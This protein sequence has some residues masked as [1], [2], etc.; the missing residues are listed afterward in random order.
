[1]SLRVRTCLFLL[2]AH[3]SACGPASSQ[4]SS[5]VGSSGASSGAEGT[6]APSSSG[7]P[8]ARVSA[9]H[10]PLDL[11]TGPIPLDPAS[12]RAWIEGHAPEI[13]RAV[14][15]NAHR[16]TQLEP[17]RRA[18]HILI[19]VPPDADD[20]TVAAARSRAEDALR[21]AQAGEDFGALAQALSEDRGS[22][23]R[24][25]DLGW[26][27]RGRL[28]A[29]FEEVLFSA[30]EAGLVRELV[31]TAFGFHVTLITGLFEG[32]DMSAADVRAD[33][34]R[35]LY[36]DDARREIVRAALTR[37]DAHTAE[38]VVRALEAALGPD[39]QGRLTTTRLGPFDA[40]DDVVP[41]L[42][43]SITQATLFALAPGER[44]A[45]VGGRYEAVVFVG[46]AREAVP[47][48]RARCFEPSDDDEA[49]DAN[50][51]L[52]QRLRATQLLDCAR[53][54]RA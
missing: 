52:L 5:E 27:P 17:Q 35:D 4:P 18:S 42:E 15:A 44:S 28:V 7:R 22:G 48:G 21:R 43:G 6:S 3:V 45:V 10:V 26:S 34:A 53:R 38:D 23:A 2:W 20:A 33:V 36:F 50:L 12:T 47:A 46:E 30:R 9:V 14:E 54:G 19:L 40:S 11:V 32:G 13:D 41:D 51:R 1:M 31:R 49:T 39:A 8:C 29:D 37:S 25:G 16:Y 24:G